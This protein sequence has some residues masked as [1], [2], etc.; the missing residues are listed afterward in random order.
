M[1]A[2]LQGYVVGPIQTN[3]YILSDEETRQAIL[4]D[5][6]PGSD[7]LIAEPE[8]QGLSLVAILMTHAHWDHI[9]CAETFHERYRAPRY[10]LQAETITASDPEINLSGEFEGMGRSYDWDK[11]VTDGQKVE[12]GPFKF[13]CLAT[14]GHTPGGVCYYFEKEGFLFAG[15]SLFEGSVGRTDF[16]G[17]SMSQLLRSLQEKVLCLPD[18]TKVFPGHGG[19]TEVGYERKYNPYLSMY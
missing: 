8:R 7:K 19:E 3:C 16:P 11:L 10:L 12:I 13:T 4:I 2:E 18:E 5:P 17:G 9:A 14:P 1:K 15:D 6:G